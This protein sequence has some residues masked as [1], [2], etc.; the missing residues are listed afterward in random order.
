MAAHLAENFLRAAWRLAVAVVTFLAPFVFGAIAGA[1]GSAAGVV[2]V[3]TVA[4]YDGPRAAILL[5][6]ALL[7]LFLAAVIAWGVWRCR[8]ITSTTHTKSSST[9][10]RRKVA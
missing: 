2:A 4:G 5:T 1:A 8:D 9:A 6:L 10:R 3:F 7:G